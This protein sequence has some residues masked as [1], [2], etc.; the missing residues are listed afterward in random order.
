[1]VVDGKKFGNVGKF[2]KVKLQIQD[3]NLELELY[4]I[5]LG[6]LYVVLGVQ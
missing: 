6:G 2:H 4:T 1:M 3:F 5:P